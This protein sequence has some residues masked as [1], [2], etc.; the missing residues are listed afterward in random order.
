MVR[1]GW[2]NGRFEIVRHAPLLGEA[3]LCLESGYVC[4]AEALVGYLPVGRWRSS[5]GKSGLRRRTGQLSTES[6]VS[7]KS[8]RWEHSAPATVGSILE[9]IFMIRG[10]ESIGEECGK[11]GPDALSLKCLA[12]TP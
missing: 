11:Q 1:R 6:V 7:G 10:K 3:C 12:K 9:G 4:R 5:V 8:R 2:I